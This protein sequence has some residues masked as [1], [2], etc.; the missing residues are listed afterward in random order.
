MHPNTDTLAQTH[1]RTRM[2][3]SPREFMKP[4]SLVDMI[5]TLFYRLQ[6][7]AAQ[8]FSITDEA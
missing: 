4:L 3:A 8:N 1:I 7:A 2:H 5:I 6:V